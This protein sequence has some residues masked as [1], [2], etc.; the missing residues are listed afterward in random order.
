MNIEDKTVENIEELAAR[1]VRHSPSLCREHMPEGMPIDAPEGR[2]ISENHPSYKF[3][4]LVE[5]ELENRDNNSK[6]ESVTRSEIR[7]KL[8]S[9]FADVFYQNSDE[10]SCIKCYEQREESETDVAIRMD[11]PEDYDDIP[12][13]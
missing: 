7:A 6:P 13:M 1:F 9:T 11:V 12:E 8:R 5:R 3:E 2:D 10:R 4:K